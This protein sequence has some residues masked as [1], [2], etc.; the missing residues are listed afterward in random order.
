M[1][2]LDCPAYLDQEGAVRCGLPTEVRCRFIMCSTDGPLEC[3]MI[4]CPA[5]HWFNGPIE[6]LA[7]DRTDKHDPGTAEVASST[8]H[9]RL[10]GTHEGRRCGGGFAIGD[11]LAGPRREVS[12]PNTAPA[13]YLGRPAALWLTAMRPRRRPASTRYPMEATVSGGYRTRDSGVLQHR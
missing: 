12:R 4:R 6:S 9:D 3:A 5:G 2:F 10:Q 8:G 7:W 11:L 1:M 13:C